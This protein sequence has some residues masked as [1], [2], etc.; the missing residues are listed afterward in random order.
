MSEP[1]LPLYDPN[2]PP[3]HYNNLSPELQA[4][5]RRISSIPDDIER[6]A[7]F[8]RLHRKRLGIEPRLESEA[9]CGLAD[10]G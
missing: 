3:G 5:H 6:L 10:Q 7:E 1:F 8:T 4:E 9:D 2:S